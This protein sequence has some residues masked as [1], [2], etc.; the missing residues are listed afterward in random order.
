MSDH[1]CN[2]DDTC[3][4]IVMLKS[5][6]GGL[7]LLIDTLMG[8]SADGVETTAE[9]QRR[10]WEDGKEA[11]RQRR[12]PFDNPYA[13]DITGRHLLPQLWRAGLHSVLDRRLT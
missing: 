8:N 1:E 3:D 7:Y 2:C 9:E 11:G 6:A 5:T 10:A 13:T 12:P 4:Y